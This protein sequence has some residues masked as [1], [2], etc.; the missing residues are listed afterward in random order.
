MY[1]RPPAISHARPEA[2]KRSARL[3]VRHA[4]QLR[5]GLQ[6][7]LQPGGGDGARGQ[8]GHADELDH[9]FIARLRQHAFEFDVRV[10]L[11]RDGERRSDLR[12]CSAQRLHAGDVLAAADAAGRDQRDFPFDA[13]RAQERERLRNDVLKLKT[14][15]VQVGKLPGRQRATTPSGRG[16]CRRSR[17]RGSFGSRQGVSAHG[18]PKGSY[19]GAKYGARLMSMPR[20][21]NPRTVADGC[22]HGLMQVKPRAA[23]QFISVLWVRRPTRSQRPQCRGGSQPARARRAAA[24]RSGRRWRR[25]CPARPRDTRR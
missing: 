7:A 13:G 23:Q 17:W 16:Q 1:D 2:D 24:T 11:V 21:C 9:G 6:V 15:V 12:R 8:A 19:R 4:L 25:P 14:R 22:G 3:D 5:F 20:G 10:A 18:R